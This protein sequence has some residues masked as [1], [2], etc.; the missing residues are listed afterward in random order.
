MFWPVWKL[1]SGL[2]RGWDR[3]GNCNAESLETD[4][5]DYL[6]YRGC[7]Q[8]GLSRLMSVNVAWEEVAGEARSG[9]TGHP[10]LN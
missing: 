3:H 1:T 6:G 4:L 9:R 7:Q 10:M 2:W 8:H 5:A